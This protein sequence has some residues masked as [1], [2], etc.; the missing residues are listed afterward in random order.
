MFLLLPLFVIPPFVCY[1]FFATPA[2][3]AKFVEDT[4]ARGLTPPLAGADETVR[5]APG[6]FRRALANPNV[7][8]SSLGSY[9]SGFGVLIFI[10]GLI[11]AYMRK[12]PAANNPWGAGATTL[13]WTLSS[14][15][16]FHQFEVLPRVQ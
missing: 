5:A 4:R 6:A 8:V 7:L 10:Y 12:V 9:I 16:P 13:E 15:P 14:P 2:N 11:D 1:W 3:Y